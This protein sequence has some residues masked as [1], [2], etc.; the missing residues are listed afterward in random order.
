R[1]LT[2]DRLLLGL[3]QVQ[4][5]VD[6]RRQPAQLRLR[7][8]PF[9]AA[10]FRPSDCLTSVSASL[11]SSPGG[12]SGPPWSLLRIPRTAAQYPNT[13]SPAGSSGAVPATVADRPSEADAC[14]RLSTARSTPRRPRTFRRICTLA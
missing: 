6:A 2:P 1:D 3:D 10:R 7:G 8:P 13:T 11:I 9:C 5:P 12:W 14:R 4:T